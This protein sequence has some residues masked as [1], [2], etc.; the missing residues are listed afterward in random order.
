MGILETQRPAR[1]EVTS[2]I[3][4]LIRTLRHNR[5]IHLAGTT[6]DQM[7]VTRIRIKILRDAKIILEAITQTRA[8]LIPVVVAEATKAA[9]EEIQA[10]EATGHVNFKK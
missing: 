4:E 9:A 1:R 6:A 2:V 5:R 10:V 8:A 7:S 3:M